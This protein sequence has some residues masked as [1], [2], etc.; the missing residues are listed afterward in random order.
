MLVGRARITDV[1]GDILS[2]DTSYIV[3]QTL[4]EKPTDIFQ[5]GRYDDEFVTENGSLL[6][7]KRHC[8]YDSSIILNSLIY[9]I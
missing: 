7:R 8:I 9:P 5:A 4:V 3:V 2:V 1:A 6:L